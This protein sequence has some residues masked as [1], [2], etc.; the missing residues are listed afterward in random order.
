MR[1]GH[2]GECGMGELQKRYLLARVKSCKLDFCKY[3]IMG[4]KC[5]VQFKTSTHKI[6]GIM[7]YVH[8]DI[9]GLAK[10]ISNGGSQ[11]YMS[12]IDHYSRK[13]WIYL[14]KNKSDALAKFKKWKTKLEGKPSALEL[15]MALRI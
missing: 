3:C 4:K 1:L 7:D 9:W 15:I 2:I 8:Y 6:K 13:V 11:Y 14:F 10:V 12:L 5:E